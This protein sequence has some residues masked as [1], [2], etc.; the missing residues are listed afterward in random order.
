MRIFSGANGSGVDLTSA[1]SD[2]NGD[3]NFYLIEG[4]YGYQVEKYSIVSAKAG[5]TVARSAAQTL[6]YSLA[7]ITVNVGRPNYIVRIFSGANGSGVDL[8][9]AKSDANGDTN[10]YLIEGG[11]GFLVE[12]NGARSAIVP[13]TV[14]RST[15]QILSYTLAQITLNVTNS[16][17]QPLP[18]YTV[19]IF[20]GT[21]GSGPLWGSVK[22]DASGNALFYLVEGGYQYQVEKNAYNSGKQ[23]PGGFVVVQGVDAPLS[24][25]VP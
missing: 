21:D 3:T 6:T 12:K 20:I 16:G 8:T 24:H 19:R 1:K 14:V 9:S 25:V 15:N 5:F 10:F 4:D 17:G 22:S 18:N 7:Q 23:P 13:F 2:A 11:Y